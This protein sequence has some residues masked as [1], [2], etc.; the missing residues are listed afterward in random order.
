MTSLTVKDFLTG[1]TVINTS[2]SNQNVSSEL[3]DKLG[4]NADSKYKCDKVSISSPNHQGMVRKQ[5]Y[6]IIIIN[7]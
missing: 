7:F 1:P 3:F 6:K 5:D 4:P 2:L